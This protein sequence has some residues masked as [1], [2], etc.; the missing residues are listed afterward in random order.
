MPVVQGRG[1]AD[2][3][4]PSD[5]QQGEDAHLQECQSGRQ[6]PVLLLRQECS[7]A[8]LQQQQFHTQH[9]RCVS[10]YV[11]P[12]VTVSSSSPT[13]LRV[14]GFSVVSSATAR[15]NPLFINYYYSLCWIHSTALPVEMYRFFFRIISVAATHDFFSLLINLLI[16]FTSI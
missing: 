1:E 8:C 11:W 9:Y 14:L 10:V 4:E 12:F 16:I 6:R 13:L 15:H 2:R 5:Q 3:E 7:R